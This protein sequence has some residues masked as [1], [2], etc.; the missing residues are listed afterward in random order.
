MAE[1]TITFELIRKI[2]REEERSPKLSKLPENFYQNVKNYLQ[3]KRKILE[4]I[5]ERKATIE[6]KNIERLVEDIFNRR[7]RKIVT[8]A[9]NSARV[10][11]TVENLTEEEREFFNKVVAIIRERRDE[12]LKELIERRE[13]KESVSMVVFKEAVPEFLGI[14]MKTYGPF[15]KGDIAKLPEENAKILVERGLAEE[16][17]VSK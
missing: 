5:E 14:D 16:F 9:I 17:K 1:E 11:L 7:E 6:M 8:Q 12:F 4:K 13:E 15:E 2:Q 10:S 3:Q